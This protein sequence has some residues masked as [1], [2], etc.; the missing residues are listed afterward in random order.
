MSGGPNP[1][2]DRDSINHHLIVMVAAI[3]VV[4]V[5]AIAAFYAAH[6]NNNPGPAQ[7]TFIGIWILISLAIVFIQQRKIR[8][9]RSGRR[10]AGR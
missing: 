3:A 10:P 6:L 5:V 7:Q 1:S 8:R 9:V 2:A 4:D